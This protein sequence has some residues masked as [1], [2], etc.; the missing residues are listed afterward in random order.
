MTQAR[1]LLTGELIS[2]WVATTRLSRVATFRL[3]PVPQKRQAALV[4]LSR[5]SVVIRLVAA[6]G[7]AIPAAEAAAAT[8]LARI[9]SRRVAVM[10]VS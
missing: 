2:P 9:K 6:A 10:A 1:P 5:L 8:A 7:V 3:H 4:H